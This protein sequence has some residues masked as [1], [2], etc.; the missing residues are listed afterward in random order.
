MIGTVAAAWRY[1]VKSLQGEQVDGLAFAAGGAAGDRVWGILDRSTGKLL[2]GKRWPALL[3]AAARTAGEGAVVITLPSGEE[4]TAGDP[5]ADEVLS[6]WLDRPV[7][8]VGPGDAALPYELTMDPTDDDSDVWDF[9]TPPRSLVDL[10]AA[11]L[12]TDT[13]L[14]AARA[15]APDSD[16]DVRRF[17]PSLL[18]ALAGDDAGEAFPEDAWIGR[19]VTCGEVGFTPFMLT[20]RCAMPTRAQPGLPRDLAISRKL[21]DHHA[22]NLGV[23]ATVATEGHVRVGDR[24]TLA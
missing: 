16:W 9:A 18:V 20:P 2:S 23:Y 14:A 15:L 24:V 21:T 22:N 5:A 13:S 19:T 12:L 17:R 10:A 7:A 1:P 11:H 3:T 6:A 4:W 8:L